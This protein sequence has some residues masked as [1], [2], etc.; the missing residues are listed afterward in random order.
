MADNLLLALDFGG[1]KLS[2]AIAARGNQEWLARRR[3]FTTATTDGPGEYRAMLEIARQ[4][5]AE[6]GRPLA[7]GVSFGGPVDARQG[8]VRLSHHVANWEEVPLQHNLEIEFDLPVAIDNDANVAALGEFR[9]GAGHGCQNLLYLT[10]STGIGGGWIIE[11]RPYV[12]SEGMAGEIG[13]TIVH[14]GGLLCACGRRGCLE[15]EASGLG[16]ANRAKSYLAG[17]GMKAEYLRQLATGDPDHITAKM[18]SQA[19]A[20]GD[21]LSQKILTESAQRLGLGLGNALNLMNPD[22]VILGGGVTKSGEYW[23]QV[24]RQV[25]RANA[26]PEIRVDIIPAAL[27]DDAPLW[28]AIALAEGLG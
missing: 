21:E 27:G 7:I 9:F 19:A 15:A 2:A 4:L 5:I 23:W 3:I 11:G 10:V 28:G 16:I 18:V 20:K 24:V 26:L 14:P 8:I 17:S 13:H 22:R 25:A 1:T 6:V 12:G